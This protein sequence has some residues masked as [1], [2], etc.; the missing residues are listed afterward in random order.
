[1]WSKKLRVQVPSGTPIK[2][3]NEGVCYVTAK[4]NVKPYGRKGKNRIFV[5]GKTE[6]GRLVLG[7]VFIQCESR[8]IQLEIM[9]EELE[10]NGYLIDWIDFYES[11]LKA[12]W[13]PETTLKKVGTA[14]SETL[15]KEYSEQ[16][17]WRLKLYMASKNK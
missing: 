13:Q 3:K 10:K 17:V 16:V 11:S 8:G 6:D 9:I 4:R 5:S 14:L 1:M 12:C 7:N 15:G 2:I